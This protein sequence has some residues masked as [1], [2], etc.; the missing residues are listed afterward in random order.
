M[1]RYR[2]LRGTAV[3]LCAYGVLG[4]V[5]TLAMLVVGV[6][7]FAQVRALQASVDRERGSLVSSIRTVGATVRDAATSLAMFPVL[8][9]VVVFQLLYIRRVETR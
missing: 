5:V 1:F 9:L 7:T 8:L 6:A 2:F 3:A 4:V